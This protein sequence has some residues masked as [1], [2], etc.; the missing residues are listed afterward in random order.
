MTM[1]GFSF[2]NRIAFSYLIGTALL[3]LFVFVIIYNIVSYTVNSHV[4]NN[5]AYEVKAHLNEISVDKQNVCVVNPKEWLELEYKQ[6][7]INPVFVQILDAQQKHVGK[8]PN[9]K[10]HDL[11]F[12]HEIKDF[13]SF[14]TRLAGKAIRQIQFPVM[15]DGKLAGYI[16][17]A[18]SLE[19]ANIVLKNLSRVLWISYPI[20]LILLFIAARIIAGR[21]IR[22]IAHITDTAREITRENLSQRIELPPNRDELYVLSQTINGLLERIENAVERERQFTSDASHELRTPLA[23]VKGT[24]EVLIRKPREKQEYEDKI[25]FCIT[26]VDRLNKLVDELLLLARFENRKEARQDQVSLHAVL[27]DSLDRFSADMLQ[28]NITVDFDNSENVT[29]VSDRDLLSIVFENLISNALKYSNTGGML[30]IALESRN[31]HARCRITDDG[32]GIAA[33]DLSKI[34]DQFFRSKATDHS[35]IKGTG[36]GLSIVKRLCDQLGIA[37][38]I[39]SVPGQGTSVLLDF[40]G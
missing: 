5:I 7:N 9:L 28:R 2:K 25:K 30:Q 17:I 37:I 31:G 21:S 1:F 13:S 40:K 39:E 6:L 26:E 15:S 16:L 23:V 38:H 35:G 8:T 24:L 4:D 27:M 22:P 29:V 20:I 34:Y 33:E 36:L 10:E 19:E 18:M 14:D 11:V 12:N 3:V 32:I